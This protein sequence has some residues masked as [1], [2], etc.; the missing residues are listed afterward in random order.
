VTSS[1]SA[2]NQIKISSDTISVTDKFGNSCLF[3]RTWD[4]WFNI[5]KCEVRPD[6]LIPDAVFFSNE[7]V[8]DLVAQSEE[9]Q[10]RLA[11][12]EASLRKWIDFRNAWS[13]KGKGKLLLQKKEARI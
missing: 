1:Y 11:R 4:R 9:Y 2:A 3:V 6:G 10:E 8:D 12:T 7:E 13:R 5:A